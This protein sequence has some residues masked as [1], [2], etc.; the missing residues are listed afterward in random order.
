MFRDAKHPGRQPSYEY[1][2]DIRWVTA[3]DA[4]QPAL[5][6]TPPATFVEGEPCTDLVRCV[7][8]ADLLA[9][10]AEL[11]RRHQTPESPVAINAD[12]SLTFVGEP[13]GAAFGLRL[14]QLAADAGVGFAHA[15]MF[16]EAGF[17]GTVTECRVSNR[18][19]RT[20]A[21]STGADRP[22]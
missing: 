22:T 10:L 11:T 1:Y 19:S 12:L 9:G 4:P 7:A 18:P 21:A 13:R 2:C 17:R 20:A 3:R 14:T 15:E 8:V 6:V 5:W 16:D